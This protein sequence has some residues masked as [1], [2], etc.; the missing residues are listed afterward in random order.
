M[1]PK[2]R[3][4]P[5]QNKRTFI[6]ALVLAALT[7]VLALAGVAAWMGWGKIAPAAALPASGPPIPSAD[8]RVV[9]AELVGLAPELTQAGAEMLA[10]AMPGASGPT[11]AEM[12]LLF[13]SR[14]FDL[15]ERKELLEL[16]QLFEEVYATLP[17]P[18]RSWMNEYMRL[19]RDGSLTKEASVR[20]R[21]LLTQGV[22]LLPPERRGRLQALMEK[23][24]G[25]ALEARRRAE[26]RTPPP[27]VVAGPWPAFNPQPPNSPGGQQTGAAPGRSPSPSPAHDEAY[28]RGRM[29]EAR[30][31]VDGLKEKVDELDRLTKQN[32]GS[33]SKWLDELTRARQELAAAERAIGDIEEEARKE[34]ALPG[35]F[36]E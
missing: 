7:A 22:N 1:S 19:L 13:A 28:W 32:L 11:L 29:K 31:K 26:G 18:D 17:P 27:S 12:G 5:R 3:Q 9:A 15:M 4:P 20:G 21:E 35:W 2:R 33:T 23:A 25:A 16:G 10:R 30:E 6:L 34:G 36:R 24:I 14:G 8:P